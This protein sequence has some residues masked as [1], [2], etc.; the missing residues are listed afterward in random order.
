V[1]NSSL[2]PISEWKYQESYDAAAAMRWTKLTV[3]G[4]DMYHTN[5]M[6]LFMDSPPRW[7][8]TMAI[9]PQSRIEKQ[10]HGLFSKYRT[11]TANLGLLLTPTFVEFGNPDIVWL[12]SKTKN[13][14]VPVQAAFIA[15]ALGMYREV[16]L[17]F[18]KPRKGMWIRA[19]KYNRSPMRSGVVG[20]LRE[21]RV[22]EPSLRLPPGF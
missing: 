18:S 19:P 1:A 13:F 10:L 7:L 2:V 9:L 12:W 21:Y 4:R 20:M 17:Y 15:L 11:A 22:E 16:T 5:G 8:R 6:V 14:Y 3:L